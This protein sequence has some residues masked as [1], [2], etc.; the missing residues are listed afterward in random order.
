MD[1]RTI[2]L[3]DHINKI[4]GLEGR[5]DIDI[6]KLIDSQDK[7]YKNNSYL[8]S[9]K[10]TKRPYQSVLKE[11]NLRENT[12]IEVEGYGNSVYDENITLPSQLSNINQVRYDS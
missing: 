12:P 2:N 5:E 11:N 1:R 4:T 10:L 8:E 6:D 7:Q 3:T 9:L